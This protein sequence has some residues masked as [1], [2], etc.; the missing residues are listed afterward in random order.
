MIVLSSRTWPNS[1]ERTFQKNMASFTWTYF[2]EEHGLIHMNVLSRRTWPHSLERTFQKNMASFTWMYFPEEHGLIHLNV[3]SSRTWPHSHER[4]FQKNN[5]L[6]TW[7]S[8]LNKLLV[9]RYI[10]EKFRTRSNS[11]TISTG[12]PAIPTVSFLQ[13]THS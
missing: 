10:A 11:K 9:W 4:T 7:T 2:P 6:L 5:S 13:P 8:L 12:C 1:H 3:L